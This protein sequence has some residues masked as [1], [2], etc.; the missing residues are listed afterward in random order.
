[1][2]DDEIRQAAKDDARGKDT[3]GY[4]TGWGYG[5]AAAAQRGLT[6]HQATQF[7]REFSAEIRRRNERNARR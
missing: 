4:P 5:N 2:S 1:M 3:G 7:D 6:G